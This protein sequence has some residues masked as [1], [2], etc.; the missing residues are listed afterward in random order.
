[1]TVV[2]VDF[3]E[4][5]VKILMRY[6]CT[7]YHNYTYQAPGTRYCTSHPLLLSAT[8]LLVLGMIRMDCMRIY[9]WSCTYLVQPK[10]QA[11]RPDVVIDFIPPLASGSGIPACTAVVP[12]G[13]YDILPGTGN[14]YE[15]YFILRS[16]VYRYLFPGAH[17]CSHLASRL[18]DLIF[19]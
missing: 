8:V 14:R 3:G 9:W 1:M 7:G 5:A 18:S 2:I 13:G 12:S 6:L 16:T 4:T 15:V 17:R 19:T 10:H 11:G